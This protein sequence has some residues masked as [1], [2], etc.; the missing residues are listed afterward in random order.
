M[1][2]LKINIEEVSCK[3]RS[4]VDRAEGLRLENLKNLKSVQQVRSE[5]FMKEKERLTVKYG[6]DHYRVKRLDAKLNFNVGFVKGLDMEIERASIVYDTFDNETWMVDGRVLDGEGKGIEGVT[7]SLYDR[8]G[9]PVPA[10]GYTCTRKYGYFALV[11]AYKEGCKE[12][13]LPDTQEFFLTVTDK[14]QNVLCR[15]SEPLYVKT[16]QRVQRLMVITGEQ[17]TCTPPPKTKKKK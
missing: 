4:A 2:Q 5:S 10:A 8:Q 11:Y 1:D 15:D 7:V 12:S 14:N 16:G 3:F 9:E 6:A 13:R 17:T